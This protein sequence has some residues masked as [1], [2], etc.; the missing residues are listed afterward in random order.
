MK[1]LVKCKI[2]AKVLSEWDNDT[3]VL[4]KKLCFYPNLT[5]VAL[6]VATI[7]AFITTQANVYS[8][9]AVNISIAA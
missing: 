3:S 5:L 9:T 1:F 7:E 6:L 2:E 4:Q 8:S